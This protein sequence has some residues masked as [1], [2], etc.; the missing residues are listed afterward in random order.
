M[1]EGKARDQEKRLQRI[2]TSLK[3]RRR[4]KEKRRSKRNRR[5]NR[6]RRRSHGTI[7]PV[8]SLGLELDWR[9][10]KFNRVFYFLSTLIQE[11]RE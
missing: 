2:E 3:R 9:V 10:S 6:R 5:R 7:V 11:N 8:L 1:G 4:E